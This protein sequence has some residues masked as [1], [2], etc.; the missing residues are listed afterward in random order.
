MPTV[1]NVAVSTLGASGVRRVY[2]V[3]DI[4]NHRQKLS[5]PPKVIFKQTKGFTLHASSTILSGRA[6]EIV[7]LAKSNLRDLGVK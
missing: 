5:M 1:D 2:K 7:K 4:V 6:D 3:I